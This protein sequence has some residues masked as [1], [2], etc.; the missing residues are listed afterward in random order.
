MKA[1][2][3]IVTSLIFCSFLTSAFAQ[4][5]GYIDSEFILSKMPDYVKAQTDMEAQ[6]SKYEKE[7]AGIWTDIDKLKE[8]YR[9]EEILLTD[10][11][12]AERRKVIDD[13]QKTTTE[14]QNKV[15]GY[16]GLLY[17]KKQEIMK[18]V[19][20]RLYEAVQKVS[21]VKKLDI[22]FDKASGDISIIYSNPV[23]D[24]SDFVLEAMGIGAEDTQK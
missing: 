6:A 4:K 15:F 17:L 19:Q 24:Y 2:K 18:P 3:K 23:H 1:L 12:K 10:A 13:K 16:K 7:I 8:A 21:R 9:A 11:L 20:D 5:I 22:V 14:Y